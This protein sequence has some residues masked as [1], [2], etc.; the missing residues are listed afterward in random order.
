[1]RRKK[2]KFLL[3]VT[4]LLL[5]VGFW[6]NEPTGTPISK[7][8]IDIPVNPHLQDFVEHLN[9]TLAWLARETPGAAVAFVRGDSIVYSNGFGVTKIGTTD[10]VSANTVF[11]IGSVSKGFA[12]VLAGIVA[13]E[14]KLSFQDDVRKFLPDFSLKTNDTLRLVHLLSHTSG[15]PY[16]AYSTMIEDNEDRDVMIDQLSTLKLIGKPGEYYSYQNVGYSIIE[17]VIEKIEKMKFDSA[18][19]ERIFKPLNMS[20][21]SANRYGMINRNDIA[22]P[23]FGS[24]KHWRKGNISHH[25]YNT[26]AAGG[27][28]ASANDM[29]QWLKALLGHR[30][31]VVSKSTL[32]SLYAPRVR[33]YIKYKQFARWKHVSKTYY[34]MG[35]RI[36]PHEKDTVIYHGGYV[37][38]YSSRIA[39]VPKEDIGICILSNSPSSFASKSVP[40]FLHLYDRYKDKI[41]NWVPEHLPTTMEAGL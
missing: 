18:L 2:S 22:Y 13:Q 4:V 7:H 26:A 39:L 23:H 6:V 29:G 3:A 12:S 34:G 31:D 36:V 19:Q 27:V 5:P 8:A 10:S 11:R 25:Y 35:W 30:P 16:Q 37:N 20:T 28:N 32:D 17:P 15:L 24:S 38:G 1:M 9:D 41:N 40:I 33:T 21:A 14:N